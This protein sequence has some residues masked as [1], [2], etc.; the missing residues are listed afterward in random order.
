M[1]IHK[2]KECD[3]CKKRQTLEPIQIGADFAD[4][5]EVK[6]GTYFTNGIFRGVH[7]YCSESCLI[8]YVRNRPARTV[9]YNNAQSG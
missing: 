3:E 4:W 6:S 8:R 2:Y 9:N 1:T 5:I 7:H